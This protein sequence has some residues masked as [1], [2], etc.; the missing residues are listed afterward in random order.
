MRRKD[1]MRNGFGS[2]T[3]F[4]KHRRCFRERFLAITEVLHKNIQAA[5]AKQLA[6]IETDLNTIRDQNVVLE[7]E[8]NP[9]LRRRLA[10]AV[11][12]ETGEIERIV[13]V[14]DGASAAAAS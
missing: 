7:S 4:H 11:K 2:P 13:R 8:R 3:L 12:I 10:E 6:D 5:I 14:I 9:E 1:I